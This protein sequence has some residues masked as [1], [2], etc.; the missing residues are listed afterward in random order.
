MQ[1]RRTINRCEAIMTDQQEFNKRAMECTN[2]RMLMTGSKTKLVNERYDNG[3]EE[4]SNVQATV[5]FFKCVGSCEQTQ[6]LELKN[7]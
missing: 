6:V 1:V 4:P 2:H 5:Y 3:T 7:K